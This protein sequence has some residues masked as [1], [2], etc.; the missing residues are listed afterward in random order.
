MTTNPD[1]VFLAKVTEVRPQIAI[2]T[3]RFPG[4]LKSLHMDTLSTMRTTQ[5]L[6]RKTRPN[7][8]PQAKLP[9][10]HSTLA[11]HRLR[12]I[13]FKL[14]TICFKLR[15][16]CPGFRS[17]CSR[18]ANLGPG[19][20]CSRF[21]SVCLRFGSVCLR[22]GAFDHTT[23]GGSLCGGM[24]GLCMEWSNVYTIQK[25]NHPDPKPG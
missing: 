17:V 5:D 2:E 12:T 18:F 8:P 6:K 10:P 21:G 4:L 19:S 14:R 25:R 24:S 7:H 22:D 13:C 15:S 23:F 9:I 20:V 3:R 11:I 16:D 1:P